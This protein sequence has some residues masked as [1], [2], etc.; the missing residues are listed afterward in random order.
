MRVLVSLFKQP[1]GKTLWVEYG[2]TGNTSTVSAIKHG[3]FNPVHETTK[4]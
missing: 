3:L 1:S 4:E 2:V